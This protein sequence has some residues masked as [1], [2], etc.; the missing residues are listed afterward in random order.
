MKNILIILLSF[1]KKNLFSFVKK[2]MFLAPQAK[3][4]GSATLKMFG[5]TC[6]LYFYTL[7][8]E[9]YPSISPSPP[10]QIT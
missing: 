4:L 3:I 8:F 7:N 9:M 6:F 10:S 5:K 2:N 1:V